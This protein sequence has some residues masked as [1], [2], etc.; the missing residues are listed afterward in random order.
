LDPLIQVESMEYMVDKVL[1]EIAKS[2][3]KKERML[4][5]TITKRSS[6]ELTDFLLEN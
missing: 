6:E 5:T 3:E 4:I 2:V 1:S